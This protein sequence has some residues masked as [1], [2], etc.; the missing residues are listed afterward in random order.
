MDKHELSKTDFDLIEKG[1]NALLNSGP[2]PALAEKNQGPAQHV[3]GRVYRM[4]GDRR[5]GCLNS[6]YIVRLLTQRGREVVTFPCR[7]CNAVETSSNR[8][9]WGNATMNVVRPLGSAEIE[10]SSEVEAGGN[11]HELARGSSAVFR[12][13]EASDVEMSSDNLAGLLRRVSEASTREIEN[14]VGDLQALR[15][16]L[17]TDGNRIQRDI[18]EYAELTQ[19]VMQLTKIISESVKKLPTALS[20]KGGA[21]GG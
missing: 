19:Q 2:D 18:T 13:G 5:R 9:I 6:L 17:H 1:L 15:K 10:K 20:V 8:M 12:P 21:V 4:V 7:Q 16:K 11:I 14:L 3:H